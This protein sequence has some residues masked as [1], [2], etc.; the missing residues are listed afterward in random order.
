MKILATKSL[1]GNWGSYTYPIKVGTPFDKDGAVANTA[2]AI[3]IV[4]DQID[5]KPDSIEDKLA[6][7][8][9]GYVDSAELGYTL[10]DAAVQAMKGITIYD[11]N[12]N[13]K[14]NG[15]PAVTAE[16]NGKVLGVAEGKWAAVA[17]GGG[18][19]AL[20]VHVTATETEENSGVYTYEADT[21]FADV[22]AALDAGTD[23]K[24][25]LSYPQSGWIVLCSS[26]GIEYKATN[27]DMIVAT[28]E[29]LNISLYHTADGVTDEHPN[30]G[31]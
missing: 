27:P 14:S 19:G 20:V 24:Y 28:M 26:I 13:S 15:L 11:A 29:Y 7:M 1:K 22:I 8:T 2:A 5:K 9:G 25:M 17:G 12:G 21:T 3:G 10:S 16:D 30:A 6:V 18:G 31:D 4:M 23:V